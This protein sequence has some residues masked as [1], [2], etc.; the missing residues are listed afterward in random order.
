MKRPKFITDEHMKYL[1]RM[2][3]PCLRNSDISVTTCLRQEFGLG[4][5]ATFEV[6]NYWLE[7]WTEEHNWKSRLLSD[8][9]RSGNTLA[10]RDD[11]SQPIKGKMASISR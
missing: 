5:D 7:V 2:V 10:G 1:D 6:I 11:S 3:I 9:Q 8:S 4:F